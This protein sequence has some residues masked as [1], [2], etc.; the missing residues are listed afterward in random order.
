MRLISVLPL[1]LLLIIAVPSGA[2]SLDWGVR[3]GTSS[4]G[5]SWHGDPCPWTD[6]AC[7]DFFTSNRD[8]RS[9]TAGAVLQVGIRPRL[10]FQ[11]ELW[12]VRKGYER[13]S[14]T[15]HFTY[16]EAPLLLRYDFGDRRVRPYV[17][18]GFTP[19]LE[20][21]CRVISDKYF[22][23]A[24]VRSYEG[25]CKDPHP[26]SGRIWTARRDVGRTV[27]TG[28]T[29][30][31]AP[32]AWSLEVRYTRGRADIDQWESGDLGQGLHRTWIASLGYT[33]RIRR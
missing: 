25:D 23:G 29:L 17:I 7:G 1:L 8:R 32:A 27:G 30:K 19:A 12:I 18:A 2:Q 24:E 11:P 10:S 28:L 14:P 33:A 26:V 15:L 4:S 31:G 20:L 6:L 5:M 22:D 3:L 9:V 16:A 21:A 13:T